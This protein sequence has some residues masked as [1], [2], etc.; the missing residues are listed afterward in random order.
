MTIR[1]ATPE[2]AEALATLLLLAIKPGAKRLYLKV[3]FQPVSKKVLFGQLM[4]HLQ[5]AG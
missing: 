5:Y 4:E 1:K 3:G 2:V